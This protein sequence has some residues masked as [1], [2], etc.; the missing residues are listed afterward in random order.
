MIE[1]PRRQIHNPFMHIHPSVAFKRP[2]SRL[3]HFASRRLPVLG[4]Q[5]LL[6][7]RLAPRL[8]RPPPA[9]RLLLA[10]LFFASAFLPPSF[11]VS[12]HQSK[13][14]PV[15]D[16]TPKPLSLG[17]IK[18]LIY[19]DLF[20]IPRFDTALNETQGSF[21]TPL[22]VPRVSGS[23][24]ITV[25]RKFI[26]DKLESVNWTVELDSFTA[27]TPQGEKEMVN[28]IATK[29]PNATNRIILAAHYD[30]K[31]F[32]PPD[33]F[34]GATDSAGP[35]AV[36]LDLVTKINNYID[37]HFKA[38]PGPVMPRKADTTIQVIFF[39][40]EEAFEEWSETDSLYGSRHLAEKWEAEDKL[41]GIE[42]F[43]LLDLL[44]GKHP[45]VP[46]YS[47]ETSAAY[48]HLSAIELRLGDN[49]MLTPM[50]APEKEE[51]VTQFNEEDELYFVDQDR[52]PSSSG[53][54]IEDDHTPFADRGVPVLHLIPTPFP[55]FWHTV[56]DNASIIVPEVLNDFA[57]MLRVFVA[58]YLELHEGLKAEMIR[59]PLTKDK[60][61]VMTAD[62]EESE[63]DG[64]GAA[65]VKRSAAEA[66]TPNTEPESGMD[67]AP[68]DTK[69]AEATRDEL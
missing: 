62:Q 15:L 29:N 43:V 21:I 24:N 68:A 49:L 31:Y 41:K 60:M 11:R 46:N 36:L 19:N 18:H 3:I 33:V 12:A 58:E 39:D 16:Y 20:A 54:K 52:S 9:A 8:V 51:D 44:G 57:V 32:A 23:E 64:E 65:K 1:S 5:T 13:T 4:P 27:K 2:Q 7:A 45:R 10:A 40:G 38:L 61:A 63:D 47:P 6:M 67:D 59:D 50:K 35:C 25:V 14:T 37:A 30:S 28:I 26:V 56:K 34:V 69:E 48:R 17:A 66:D 42:L 53:M 22:L 55:D